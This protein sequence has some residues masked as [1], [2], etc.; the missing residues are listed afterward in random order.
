MQIKDANAPSALKSYTK[1]TVLR[2]STRQ[3]LLDLIE[4]AAHDKVL[5]G[6][7]ESSIHQGD[8]EYSEE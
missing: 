4:R 6:Y 8:A 1:P 7:L 5:A 3:V 2:I